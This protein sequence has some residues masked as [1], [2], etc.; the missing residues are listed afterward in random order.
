MEVKFIFNKPKGIKLCRSASNREVKNISGINAWYS[1]VDVIT[2]VNIARK[3]IKRYDNERLINHFSKVIQHE[4]LHE[5]IHE[6]TGKFATE[7]EEE[8]CEKICGV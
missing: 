5:A 4:G 2:Y 8:I 7:K 1:Y 3:G 6:I